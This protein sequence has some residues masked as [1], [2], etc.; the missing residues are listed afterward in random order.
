MAEEGGVGHL[1]GDVEGSVAVSRLRIPRGRLCA[2]D[3]DGSPHPRGQRE[4]VRE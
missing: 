1:N 2:G 3:G 4:G